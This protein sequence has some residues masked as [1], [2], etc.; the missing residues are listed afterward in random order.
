MQHAREPLGN[1]AAAAL[2]VV[3][4]HEVA[5]QLGE[6]RAQVR[7]LDVLGRANEGD[8]E[9]DEVLELDRGHLLECLRVEL[10]DVLEEVGDV[11]HDI[12]GQR[13]EDARHRVGE[14][15]PLRRRLRSGDEPS[16]D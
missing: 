16:G 6:G 11:G 14:R 13:G 1:V 10:D 5:E 8:H 9:R 3:V 2:V 15:Q 4:G 7:V 12:L